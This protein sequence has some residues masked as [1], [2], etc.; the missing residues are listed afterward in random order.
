MRN[1]LR[2]F[3]LLVVV[4]LVGCGAS[5]PT[6][7]PYKMD[8][9]QGNLVTSEM[10]LKLRP[11]MNKSQVRFIMGTPLLL[12]SF[13]TNRW[14]YFYQLRKQGKIINQRRVILDFEN[15]LLVHVRGDVVPKASTVEDVIQQSE[16]EAESKKDGAVDQSVE[17]DLAVPSEPIVVPIETPIVESTD[18][19]ESAESTLAPVTA[20][21]SNS[22]ANVPASVL[23][24]PIPIA[25]AT[26]TPAAPQ[27]EMLQETTELPMVA[28]AAP[29][30]PVVAVPSEGEPTL[31][32]PMPI[33]KSSDKK[34][35]FRLDHQLDTSHLEQ[36]EATVSE[37]SATESVVQQQKEVEGEALPPEEEPDFFERMLEKIGF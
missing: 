22:D 7:K 2:I 13:H 29:E 14:D 10:L 33:S 24:V 18:V 3:T 25:P 28:P 17:P 34:M 32:A 1:I 16:S 35:I 37:A 30:A 15:D 11:G 21:E 26:E 9:Q 19:V 31:T 5:V 23:V 12:D 20:P 8:I 6:I 36:E 27:V 4:A